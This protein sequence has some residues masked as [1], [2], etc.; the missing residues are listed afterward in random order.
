MNKITSI[1]KLV[2]WNVLILA[3]LLFAINRLCT[4]LAHREVVKNERFDTEPYDRF[5]LPNYKGREAYA[6]IIYS[7]FKALSTEYSPYVEWKR[8]GF[9]GLTTR[10]DSVTGDRLHK[11]RNENK[12]DTVVRFFG[13]STMW[14]TGA[15]NE[16][17]IPGLADSLFGY[18]YQVHNHGESGYVS[19]QE[20]DKLLNIYT[21]DSNLKNEIVVFYDGVN[22]VNTPCTKVSSYPTHSYEQYLATRVGNEDFSKNALDVLFLKST[23]EYLLGKFKKETTPE[24]KEKLFFDCHC[25][26]DKVELVANGLINNWKLAKSLVEARGGKF[27]A[28]LQPVVYYSKPRKDHLPLEHYDQLKNQYPVVYEALRKKIKELN[29][30]W[31]I[32]LSEVLDG[33]EYY[34]VDFCHLSENGNLVIA[35]K[36]REALYQKQILPAPA[37]QSN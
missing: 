2:F 22:D 32:D 1:V 6:K 15:D 18:K 30:D 31:I 3:A 7:E 5:L 11:T 10:I 4:F 8:K 13:G 33:N 34:Y 17:T 21:R 27:M 26:P 35:Q 19:R 16:H 36:I 14:G 12:T 37:P 23:R 28:V 20:L 9:S 24:E 25:N 29:Y